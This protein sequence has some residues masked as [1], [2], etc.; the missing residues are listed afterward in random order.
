MSALSDPEQD[1]VRQVKEYYDSTNALYLEHLGSTFQAGLISVDGR[2][3]GPNQHTRILAARAGLQ[4]GMRVLDAGCGVCGPALEIARA[5][6]GVVVDGVTISPEQL[7]T[8]E[9][10]IRAAGMEARVR[11]RQADY[12]ALPFA[13]GEF[14]AV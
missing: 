7:R 13:E 3:V 12:H 9:E 8:A 5:I 6:E 14:D 1:R 10:R 4:P 11:V 2:P